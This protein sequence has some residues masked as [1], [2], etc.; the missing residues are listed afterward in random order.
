MQLPTVCC[1]R[2]VASRCSQLARDYQVETLAETLPGFDI[3]NWYGMSGPKGL[4][5]S[6]VAKL[7]AQLS[8]VLAD[9]ELRQT[10]EK[11]AIEVIGTSPEAFGEFLQA[12]LVKW[13]K[14]VTSSGLKI[15]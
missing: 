10:F 15:D 8:R 2:V 12:E 4:P 13:G 11:E 1:A 6:T 7:H 9:A 3:A 5:R 14:L